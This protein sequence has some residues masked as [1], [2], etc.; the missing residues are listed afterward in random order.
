MIM[1]ILKNEIKKEYSYFSALRHLRKVLNANEPELIEIYARKFS[2]HPGISYADLKAA[3]EDEYLTDEII[4]KWQNEYAKF[5]YEHVEPIIKKVAHSA[6]SYS[7][8]KL[9][10]PQSSDTYE[11]VNE[12]ISKHLAE[13]ITRITDDQQ[14]ALN[15][16]IKRAVSTGETSSQLV[17]VIRPLVGLTKPQMTANYNY[18]N[19]LVDTLTKNGSTEK[20]AKETA[21]KKSLD[22]AAR[23][24]RK[25]A[26]DIARTEM[27]TAYNNSEYICVKE[28]QTKGY[29]RTLKKK[30]CTADNDGVCKNCRSLEGVEVDINE[31][32][33]TYFGAVL[34]PPAHT[35]CRCVVLY[36]E[37]E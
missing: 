15:Y 8:K 20:K 30:W 7:S 4:K 2:K 18:Y 31:M 25:R 36:I 35:R 14:K 33:Q 10:F 17:K 29:I 12:W 19:T 34:V 9:S 26:A 23:Q 6:F 21:H 32:F 5:V 3:I 16:I 27:A 11:T 13:H 28:A 22:Y 24:H 37:V 1:I